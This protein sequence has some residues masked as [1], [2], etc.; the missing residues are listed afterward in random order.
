M[1][2]EN[3]RKEIG[4]DKNG[5]PIYDVVC[6]QHYK[7]TLGIHLYQFYKTMRKI[8]KLMDKFK[9]P[10]EKSI[11]PHFS[12]G[13]PHLEY[14]IKNSNNEKRRVF[15]LILIDNNFTIRNFIEIL[16][17]KE[18]PK[19]IDLVNQFDFINSIEVQVLSTLSQVLDYSEQESDYFF[20]G[21]DFNDEYARLKRRLLTKDNKV[22]QKTI[23]RIIESI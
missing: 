23:N 11:R 21:Y 1:A 13:T 5:N 2:N 7:C 6:P 22:K 10:F 16:N 14:F 4:K 17:K 20:N 8:D 3:V 12:M 15:S 18:D 9:I 19:I